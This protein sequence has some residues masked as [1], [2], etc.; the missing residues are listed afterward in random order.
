[1]SKTET[2][3]FR[4]ALLPAIGDTLIV[5]AVGIL[6]HVLHPGWS[7]HDAWLT[8]NGYGMGC[9][10]ALYRQEKRNRA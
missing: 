2:G 7:L 3:Q 9:F 1:M 5:F 4:S 6:A 10:A 8:A